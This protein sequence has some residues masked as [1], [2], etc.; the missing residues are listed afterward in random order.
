MVP[1]QWPQG[2]CSDAIL[3]FSSNRQAI[4]RL[5]LLRIL[6]FI[7]KFS[8]FLGAGFSIVHSDI[9]TGGVL[10]FSQVLNPV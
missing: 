2:A 5:W 9:I 4:G 8:I 1:S 3:C 10:C 6:A 7:L